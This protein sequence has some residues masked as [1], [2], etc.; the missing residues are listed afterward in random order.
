LKPPLLPA[1]VA[2]LCIFN[3]AGFTFVEPKQET[4]GIQIFVVTAIVLVSFVV[5]W[6]FWFGSRLSRFLVLITSGIAIL[7]LLFLSSASTI[8]RA[9]IIGEALFAIF[10]FYWLFS[11]TVRQYFATGPKI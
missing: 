3:L 10:L 5:I 4:V 7:N 8:Q 2:L 6:R 1:V 9:V 11:A